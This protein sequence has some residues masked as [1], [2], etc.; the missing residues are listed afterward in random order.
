MNGRM[1]LVAVL[2]GNDP[3]YA[4]AL[5]LARQEAAR[6]ITALGL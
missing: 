2:D 1:M 5:T 3:D 6:V 4:S